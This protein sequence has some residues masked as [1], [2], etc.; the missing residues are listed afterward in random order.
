MPHFSKKSKDILATCHPKLRLICNKAIIVTDFSVL[1]GYR[2][3]ESQ[4]RAYSDGFSE[5]KFPES[6][7][8]K[9]PS[10]AV[11][12]APYPIDWNDIKR[13]YYLAGVFE[14]IAKENDIYLRWGGEWEDFGHFEV[15]L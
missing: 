8:N 10:P 11:D 3:K 4:N 13:F 14:G 12:V 2:D 1:D 7:H 5:K 15:I 9:I 6:M